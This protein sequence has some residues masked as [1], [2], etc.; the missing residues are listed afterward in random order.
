MPARER[1]G[2]P[3]DQHHP[4]QREH[5]RQVEGRH[6]VVVAVAQHSDVDRDQRERRQDPQ[7]GVA[8]EAVGE[9]A[10]VCD[11]QRHRDQERDGEEPERRDPYRAH[12]ARIGVEVMADPDTRSAQVHENG[13]RPKSLAAQG[14][15][16]FLEEQAASGREWVCET[17][18]RIEGGRRGY[19]PPDL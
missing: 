1:Q 2:D 10:V 4:Q 5:D 11:R 7:R 19:K 12:R 18:G 15:E 13:V 16:V 8:E 3:R 17:A 9:R 14:S 6:P